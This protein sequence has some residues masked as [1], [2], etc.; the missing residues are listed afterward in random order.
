MRRRGSG[1][2]HLP[3]LERFLG[4]VGVEGA[5]AGEDLVEEETEGIDVAPCRDLSALHLLRRHVPG[6]SRAHVSLRNL[7]LKTR[8]TEVCD[9][10]PAPAVDH[11][12][13]GLEVAVKDALLVSGT[14]ASAELPGDLQPLLRRQATDA[15]QE[16]SQILSVD[17]LHREEMTTLDLAH[18]VDA[19]DVRMR[20]LPGDPNLVEEP[21]QAARLPLERAGQELERDRL[22]QLK[23]VGTIDLAHPA[24]PDEGHDAV[25]LR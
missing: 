12:V 22:A 5:L 2:P 6:S 24:A 11:D 20:N 13:R 3:L 18:I 17:E 19:A 16:R 23:V 9:A 4:L 21:P 10:G 7:L 1:E 15:A 8:K 14:Q 25:T